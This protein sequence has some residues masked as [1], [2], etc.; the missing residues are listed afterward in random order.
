MDEGT[1]SFPDLRILVF[2]VETPELQE[3][4]QS[5]FIGSSVQQLNQFFG[6]DSCMCPC[7]NLV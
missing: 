2:H 7:F 1:C 5:N 3:N 4:A 6:P